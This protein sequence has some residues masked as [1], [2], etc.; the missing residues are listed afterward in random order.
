MLQTVNLNFQE[1]KNY[2]ENIKEK[3]ENKKLGIKLSCSLNEIIIKNNKKEENKRKCLKKNK[4]LLLNSFFDSE[5]KIRNIKNNINIQNNNQKNKKIFKNTETNRDFSNF[6]KKRCN[7]DNNINNEKG[8]FKNKILQNK[9]KN[10]K[11]MKEDNTNTK[12]IKDDDLE[13][14]IN[15]FIIN[16]NMIDYGCKQKTNIPMITRIKYRSISKIPHL[17]QKITE[18]KELY[19]INNIN[20]NNTNYSLNKKSSPNRKY[21]SKY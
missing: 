3:Y 13:D 14:I 12:F 21:I 1:N 9:V 8:C 10:N 16:I 4:I 7:T 6:L 15:I 19:S 11:T 17:R 2:E 20:Q 18:K 5:S